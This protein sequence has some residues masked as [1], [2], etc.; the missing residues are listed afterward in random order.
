MKISILTIS[1]N[2]VKTIE[3]A[4]KSV[5]IQKYIDW[6]HIVIDGGSTDGT[7]EILNKY[8]HLKWI[9][10]PD[11]GQ[12]DAMNKAFT[13]AT[14]DVIG[15]LNSDDY[16][17]E[18]VFEM[19]ASIFQK[20]PTPD[21]A[22]GKLKILYQNQTLYRFPTSKY[23]DISHF[24]LH[25]FPA[26]PV[27]YFYKRTIQEEIGVFPVDNHYTM[28]YWFLLRAFKNRRIVTTDTVFGVFDLHHESKTGTSDVNQNL[29]R[30]FLA[31]ADT[32]RPL[33]RAIFLAPWYKR[34]Y[35]SRLK[36]LFTP[37]FTLKN[38]LP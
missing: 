8:T 25:R 15:Y 29:R 7:I 16:Y 11:Q 28:D 2:S 14:G 30:E 38:V 34:H 13:L 36:G 1:Y 9:S 18:D 5:L 33:E 20:E 21:M 27:S 10:E 32:L 4:I 23:T 24:W 19:V 31:Y 37:L 26:N 35:I 22:V 17:C 12:S 3:R 6:E